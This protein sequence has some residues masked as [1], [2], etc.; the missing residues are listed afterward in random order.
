MDHWLQL[1]YNECRLTAFAI[2]LLLFSV[3]EYRHSWRLWIMSR[4]TRWGRHFALQIISLIMVRLFFPVLTIGFA[5][6]I[7]QRKMGFL[8][9]AHFPY[10]VNVLLGILA[11]DFSMFWL[12]RLMHKYHFLWRVH[13]VHH[14]D[15]QLDVSTGLRFHPI[16]SLLIMGIKMVAI[17]LFGVTALA[18]FI[19]EILLNFALFFA[20]MNVMLKPS[21]EKWLRKVIVT[22]GM[23][24]IHHSDYSPETNSNYGFC[25]SFWDKLL[26][27]Y[28]LSPRV[29]E[30]RLLIGLEQYRDPKYQTLENMLLVPFDVKHLKYRAKKL[31]RIRMKEHEKPLV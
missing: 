29:G 11:M 17:A 20:H 7:E 18:V 6:L 12:H 24:R 31:H 25:F 28:T 9:Q 2:A 16:E 14:M 30:R 1:Y 3:Y 26:D 10:V 27:S 23:H 21:T 22:P 19:F 8:H 4:K 13:R 5:M 15:K